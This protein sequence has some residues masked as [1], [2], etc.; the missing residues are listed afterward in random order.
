[1]RNANTH[2]QCPM[3][4]L[5]ANA[6]CLCSMLRERCKVKKNKQMKH[7]SFGVGGGGGGFNRT[8]TCFILFFILFCTFPLC[9][10][11]QCTLVFGAASSL[12]G[13]DTPALWFDLIWFCILPSYDISLIWF[14][15]VWYG[16]VRQFT[17]NICTRYYDGTP[18]LPLTLS[19]KVTDAS[20]KTGHCLIHAFALALAKLAFQ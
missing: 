12:Q 9:L 4:M 8:E 13:W 19:K 14:G 18:S 16:L 7:V 17:W 3:P 20:H 10:M 11:P 6:H 15:R 5:K 2:C 1:M